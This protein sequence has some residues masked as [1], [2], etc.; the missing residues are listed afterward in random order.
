MSAGRQERTNYLQ[1]GQVNGGIRIIPTTCENRV[2]YRK[3]LTPSLSPSDGEKVAGRPGEGLASVLPIINHT[4]YKAFIRLP[5]FVCQPSRPPPKPKLTLG[6]PGPPRLVCTY[7][8]GISS[9]SPGLRVPRHSAA[10]AGGTSYPGKR[11]GTISTLKGLQP[12]VHRPRRRGRNPFRVGEY[13]VRIPRVAR[14]SQP[15]G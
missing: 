6:P 10:K 14:S 2:N 8:K 12:C 15:L 3:P 4:W 13:L 11:R 1:G 7:P 9:V 5:P